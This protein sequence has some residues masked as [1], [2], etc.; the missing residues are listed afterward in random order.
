[1]K[2]ITIAGRIGRDA[3]VRTTQN[4]DKLASF[5]VAVDEGYGDS[6]RTLWFDV[7]YWGKRGEGLA[8]HLTK[9]TSLTVCGSL[10]TRE[11]EGK[12]YLTIRADD[13]TL[14]GGGRKQEANTG[15]GY[16]A[17]YDAQRPQSGAPAGGIEDDL[18]F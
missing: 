17:G 15:S 1:M 4:G 11:H 18:P 8:P 9:G 13:I 10:S 2:N 14:Q 5:Q 6:K 3:T 7:S 16:G 12:T